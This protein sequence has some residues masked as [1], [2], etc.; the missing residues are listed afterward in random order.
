MYQH[1]MVT[2]DGSELSECVL[3]HLESIA[4]GCNAKRVTLVRVVEPLHLP[5]G[6]ETHFPENERRRLEAD[7]KSIARDYLEQLAQKIKDKGIR[8]Q[9][10]VLN[11]KV[12]EEIV[13]YADKNE[14]DLIIM[15]SHG[16]SGPSRWV[17]GSTADRILSS[18]SVPVLMVRALKNV[19]H[20]S[21]P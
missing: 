12:V 16:H 1:I 5:G 9:F 19:P 4:L 2:M 10:E 8:A 21:R 13:N 15:S 20:T 14:V 3:P 18:S 17:W 11:G 7:S 6:L